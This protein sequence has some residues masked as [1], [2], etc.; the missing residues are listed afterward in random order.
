LTIKPE[1]KIAKE[2]GLDMNFFENRVGFD[3]TLYQE[4][5][6]DQIITLPIPKEAGIQSIL[7]NAGNIE[8]KGVELTFRYTP[9]RT[10]DFVW[11]GSLNFARNRNKIIDLYEGIDDFDLGDGIH[12]MQSY[13]I[14]GKAYGIIRTNAAAL[15][16][17]AKDASGNP[18]AHPNNGMP[19]LSWRADGRCAF[20]GRSGVW[21]DIGDI[22]PKFRFGL[23]NVFSYKNWMLQ[24]LFDG[25]IGGDMI[26]YSYSF[27]T[28]TG[29]L[30]NT[31]VGRDAAH[32][33]ISWTSAW[34]GVTYDDG[35]IPYGVFPDGFMMSQPNGPSVNVGGMSFE[36][37]YKAGYVEPTH[38]PQF[39]YRHGSW[40]TGTNDYWVFDN[41]WIALRQVSLSYNIPASVCSAL[42]IKGLNLSIYGRD[43]CYLY[44]SLPYDFNPVSNNSNRTSAIGEAGFLPMIRQFGGTVRLSF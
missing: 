5:T 28:H 40:S 27:G 9:V 41:S 29:L 25:K 13:A 3:L 21:E 2:I 39:F 12:T 16:Y 30:P 6:K 38:T 4:N 19:V 7:T 35:M 31:L 26:L 14:A 17:Q 44:N 18:I 10:R 33:G 8:N 32:G 34:N 11:N 37:A 20:P 24:F 36:E 22:N 1:R 43:L 15:P 42:R 23:D